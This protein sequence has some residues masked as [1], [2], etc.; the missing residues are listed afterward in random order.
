MPNARTLA[1]AAALG[2]L[3]LAVGAL[4]RTPSAP[5]AGPSPLAAPSSVASTVSPRAAVTPVPTHAVVPA[6]PTATP[7]TAD[8]TGEVAE[9][10]PPALGTE[11][12]GWT[13]VL[14]ALSARRTA[15][16]TAADPDLL[17]AVYVD[18]ASQRQADADTA[19]VLRRDGVRPAGLATTVV[20][21]TVIESGA[22][23]AAGAGVTIRLVDTRSAYDI[24][25]ATGAIVRTV[26]ARAE[27]VWRVRLVAEHGEWQIASIAAAS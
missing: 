6:V 16:F 27:R 12:A 19:A 10:V 8:P 1:I 2:V 5:A 18:T 25:D 22:S 13:H 15:A 24:V 7:T 20:S 21:A 26:P 23:S 11:T 14:A 4:V 3:V 17:S 9:S